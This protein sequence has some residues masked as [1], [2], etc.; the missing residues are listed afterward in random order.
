MDIVPSI[1]ALFVYVFFN[2]IFKLSPVLYLFWCSVASG[3]VGKSFNGVYLTH[4]N[5]RRI[6]H[7]A[8]LY[9]RYRY[10]STK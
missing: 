9:N 10:K 6:F 5:A 3:A 7:Y 8:S 2:V 1:V 4:P